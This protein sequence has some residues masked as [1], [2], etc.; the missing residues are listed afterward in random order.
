MED[1]KNNQLHP[2]KYCGNT[3]KGKQC[4]QCHLKMIS[5]QFDCID[6]KNRFV[7]LRCY[8]CTEKHN[9]NI[10][11]TCPDCGITYTNVS[12]KGKYFEKCYECY[13]KGFS[14][15]ELCNKRCFKQYKYCKSCYED[16]R[17]KQSKEYYSDYSSYSE[18]SYE[19]KS[20][21]SYE[22][23]LSEISK[24]SDDETFKCDKD[25]ISI[26]LN[27]LLNKT[28]KKN[29]NTKTCNNFTNNDYCIYCLNNYKLKTIK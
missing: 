14:N 16:L 15:C 25:N 3:C 27:E 9:E 29:C 11:N 28:N 8:D 13:Q 18:L 17:D 1:I 5:R 2:C 4:K 6:C 10:K 12:N 23:N 20:C 19:N 26:L 22:S 21:K 24:K 7:A